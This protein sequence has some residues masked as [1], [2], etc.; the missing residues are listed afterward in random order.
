MKEENGI[1][2]CVA[3]VDEL[4]TGREPVYDEVLF[5]VSVNVQVKL[6][7]KS[8]DRCLNCNELPFRSG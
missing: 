1:E 3:A 2:N 4:L 5:A 7:A 6:D 8:A